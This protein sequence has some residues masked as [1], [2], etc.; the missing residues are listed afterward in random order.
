MK[1]EGPVITQADG[2]N[3]RNK[4]ESGHIGG[5][6]SC[7]H[8]VGFKTERAMKSSLSECYILSGEENW[9]TACFFFQVDFYVIGG[10]GEGLHCFFF[11]FI[12]QVLCQN[13][14]LIYLSLAVRMRALELLMLWPWKKFHRVCQ[15]VWKF[16]KEDRWLI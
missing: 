3:L 12:L 5:S 9:I 13:C 4:Q 6:I 7:A 8:P 10:G 2:V 1:H 14:S 11:N 15:K 16:V